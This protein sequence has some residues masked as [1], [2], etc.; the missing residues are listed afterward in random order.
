MPPAGDLWPAQNKTQRKIP[1]VGQSLRENRMHKIEK[2]G[3]I[4]DDEC[5]QIVQEIDSFSVCLFAN[6]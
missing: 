2:D 5:G 4:T 1:D 3:K 6:E